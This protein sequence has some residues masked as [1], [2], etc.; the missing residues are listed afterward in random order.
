MY[1]NIQKRTQTEKSV[2]YLLRT[3]FCDYT[4][5]FDR[6]YKA[7]SRSLNLLIILKALCNTF[8]VGFRVKPEVFGLDTHV[9]YYTK[10]F[11]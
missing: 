7:F 10:G 5:E 8:Y 3:R 4:K 2:Y 1:E 6:K 9:L 11:W